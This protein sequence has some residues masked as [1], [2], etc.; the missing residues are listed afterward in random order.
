MVGPGWGVGCGV[1]GV[2]F[3]VWGLGSEI[4]G[5]G[6]KTW[7]VR[8]RFEVLKA[9]F[10]KTVSGIEFEDW[11]QESGFRDWFRIQ[12]SKCR[13]QGAGLRVQVSK[14]RVQNAGCRASGLAS[15]R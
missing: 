9:V 8:F 12:G 3:E 1:W 14:F 6:P 7:D 4:L 2:G 15:G 5:L 10:P 13:G 11:V